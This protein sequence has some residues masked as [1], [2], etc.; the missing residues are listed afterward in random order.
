MSQT[1]HQPGDEVELLAGE[2]VLGVLCADEYA[3]VE[4]QLAS[5]VSLAQ[6]VERW[7][8]RLF[9]LT[10]LVS[11]VAPD[12][13][14]WGRIERSLGSAAVRPGPLRT[15]PRASM[16]RRRSRG[17]GVWRPAA[18]LATAAALVLAVL[19]GIRQPAVLPAAAVAVAVLDSEDAKPA[20]VVQVFDDGRVAALP[21]QA[22]VVPADRT[23]EFWTIPEGEAAPRSL[24][25]LPAEGARSFELAAAPVTG[26]FFAI[27][28]EP[29]GG[30]PTGQPTG[31][32]LFQGL[33]AR[34]S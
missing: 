1:P 2:Y 9:A 32:I 25:L 16:P 34:V 18:L 23:L 31:P 26:Q 8:Q 12:Q 3:A 27:S 21:L 28:L 33:A 4:N 15:E 24:G 10:E 20:W 11:P 14:L 13:A 6:A 30:S 7:N 29:S 19:L 17:G 22:Q 5:D